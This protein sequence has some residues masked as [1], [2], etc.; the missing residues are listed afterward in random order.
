MPG[1]LA[2]TVGALV[3]LLVS[4][5]GDSSPRELRSARQTW[6]DTGPSGAE[7][8]FRGVRAFAILTWLVFGLASLRGNEAVMAGVF[9]F[10]LGAPALGLTA[11]SLLN[12][13][14]GG[15]RRAFRHGVTI[16]K[17]SIM[18][19]GRDGTHVVAADQ[20][21][22]VEVEA[23]RIWLVTTTGR[24]VIDV[25]DPTRL[26]PLAAVL[27][28]VANDAGAAQPDVLARPAGMST[29]EWLARLD[30]LAAAGNAAYRG[31][32]VDEGRLWSVL[33]DESAQPEDRTAAA[34]VLSRGARVRVAESAEKIDDPN[35]RARALAASNE[36]AERAAAELEALEAAEDLAK[37]RE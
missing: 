36:D 33:H 31:A 13:L 23:G 20:L 11:L 26:Q 8:F 2:L 25:E 17:K 34:R 32:D 15:G 4:M 18:I 12:R 27:R 30:A 24:N 9:A 3:F 10:L 16:D 7:M 35:V 19:E 37:M 29:R 5:L 1:S 21:R 14:F 6:F 28:G 22:G